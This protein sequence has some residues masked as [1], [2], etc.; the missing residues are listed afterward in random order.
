[1]TRLAL[2]LI[3]AVAAAAVLAAT[4]GA[5]QAA[6][7]AFLCPQNPAAKPIALWVKNVTARAYRG[8]TWC[9]DGATA[10]LTVKGHAARAPDG[11]RLALIFSGGICTQIE[12]RQPLPADRDAHQPVEQAASPPTRRGSS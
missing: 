11:S 6:T 8:S 9:N 12:G 2:T 5:R 1:M 7:N 10:K 3:L 4:G